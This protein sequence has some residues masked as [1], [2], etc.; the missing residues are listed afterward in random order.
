MIWLNVMVNKVIRLQFQ[1]LL[2][3]FGALPLPLA[4]A[5]GK[6]YKEKSQGDCLLVPQVALSPFQVISTINFTHK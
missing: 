4:K 1:T 6:E 2:P 5:N 3:Y